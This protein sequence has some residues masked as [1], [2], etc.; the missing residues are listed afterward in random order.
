MDFT[1]IDNSG[2]DYWTKTVQIGQ[3]VVELKIWDTLECVFREATFPY[4]GVSKVSILTP[5]NMYTVRLQHV[6]ANNRCIEHTIQC[7]VYS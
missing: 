1:L 7:H 5:H 3:K 6:L 4:L 2:A